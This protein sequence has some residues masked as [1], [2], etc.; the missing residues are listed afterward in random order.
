MSKD[1][2]QSNSV[3]VEKQKTICLSLIIIATFL[4]A[5]GGLYIMTRSGGPS[6]IEVSIPEGKF[7]LSLEKPIVDQS[8]LRTS[9]AK[10]QGND[11]M[12]TEGKITDKSVID[13]LTKLSFSDNTQFSGKNFINRDQRFLLSVPHPEKWQVSYNPAGLQNSNMPINSIYDRQGSHL[14]VWRE[15][16]PTGIGIQQYVT[17]KTQQLTQAG[18]ISQM[19]QVTYDLPSQT[20]FLVFTNSAT[21]GQSY[22]KAIVDNSRNAVFGA[23]ANYNQMLS[24]QETV[25]DLINM[26]GSFT[27]F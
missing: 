16:I 12:F 13:Q 18:A 3:E 23:T 2:E 10:S 27:I 20:A 22:I 14:N 15:Q 25:K 21:M 4:L 1:G 26:V 5:A 8:G 9:A 24:G 19:P 7:K 17:F 11:I 6:N